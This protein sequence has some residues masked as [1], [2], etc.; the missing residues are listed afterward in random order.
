[1]S[2]ADSQI[3]NDK[4][5]EWIVAD[6]VTKYWDKS[7]FQFQ[8]E[9]GKIIGLCMEI[10]RYLGKGFLEIVYK[11][12][13]EYEC[14]KSEIPFEREKKYVVNYKE[15]VLPHHFYADFIL[16]GKIIVEIKSQ[17]GIS[18][19]H[20]AQLKNYLAVSGSPVGLLINFGEKSLQ[21]KRF[22]LSK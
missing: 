22:A 9:T 13:L 3:L 21:F 16:F 15:I 10:H 17:S 20:S 7:D 8:E 18:S 1:M 2:A 6:P 11:D 14:I 5:E 12:A 19:D 4:D